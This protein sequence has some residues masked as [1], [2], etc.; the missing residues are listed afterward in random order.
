MRR[1]NAGN[2]A[3]MSTVQGGVYLNWPLFVSPG[4]PGPPGRNGNP[5]LPGLRGVKGE[6]QLNK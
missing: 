1:K 4:T 3:V 2:V 6:S 5:G